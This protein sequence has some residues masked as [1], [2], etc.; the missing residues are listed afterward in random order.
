[1]N[2]EIYYLEATANGPSRRIKIHAQEPDGTSHEEI[3]HLEN[4]RLAHL[5]LL[6][7][8]ILQTYEVSVDFVLELTTK[9]ITS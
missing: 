6:Q 9:L 3:I 4:V 2:R 7:Q 5:G 8:H 1:M